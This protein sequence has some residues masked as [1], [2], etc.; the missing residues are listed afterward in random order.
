MGASKLECMDCGQVIHI[1]H[2]PDSKALHDRCGCGTYTTPFQERYSMPDDISKPLPGCEIVVLE[3]EKG[4]RHEMPAFMAVRQPDYQGLLS[5][6]LKAICLTRDHVGEHLLPAETG[7]EW[8]KVGSEIAQAIRMT[9]GPK[10]SSSVSRLTVITVTSREGCRS[11][12][13]VPG[14]RCTLQCAM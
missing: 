4:G 7:W 13:P 10:P 5:K 11:G 14:C 6:A 8:F 12:L 3:D 1:W 2:N 9:S